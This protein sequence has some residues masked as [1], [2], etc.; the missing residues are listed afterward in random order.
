[1]RNKVKKNAKRREKLCGSR[2]KTASEK[3]SSLKWLAVNRKV[4]LIAK[5]IF[6]AKRSC[7]VVFAV[8]AVCALSFSLFSFWDWNSKVSNISWIWVATENL[9]HSAFTLLSNYLIVEMPKITEILRFV[10]RRAFG[11]N[12]WELFCRMHVEMTLDSGT[13]TPNI[14]RFNIKSLKL[15][16]LYF[17]FLF[18]TS[19]WMN[20]I[21]TWIKW[22]ELDISRLASKL[23]DIILV[24][25][26][27]LNWLKFVI[28]WNEFR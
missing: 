18:V 16:L 22:I 26:L 23:T 4:F 17:R 1:M 25:R 19:N 10:E 2:K 12:V 20:N 11:G 21:S 5:Y 27:R 14:F 13:I 7:D 8:F 6:Q 3:L 24:R 15:I 28:L 9:Q